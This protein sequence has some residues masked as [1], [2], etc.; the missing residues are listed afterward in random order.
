[1]GD[2]WSFHW[3][4]WINGKCFAALVEPSPKQR[5]Y[6]EQHYQEN[7]YFS[8]S[9]LSLSVS[10]GTILC[11]SPTMPRSATLKMG[12]NL[13]LLM[14]MICGATRKSIFECAEIRS[15]A[16]KWETQ[17]FTLIDG[18]APLLELQEIYIG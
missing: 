8:I 9:F 3:E 1:M 17:I 5:L 7:P 6:K 12:A 14:A 16:N 10:M 13:S 11:R 2:I 18:E 15:I 4:C